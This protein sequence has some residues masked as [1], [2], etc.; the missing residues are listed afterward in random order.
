M[1]FLYRMW[2][3]ETR[4]EEQS[5]G[6]TDKYKTIKICPFIINSISGA[7]A[8]AGRRSSNATTWCCYRKKGLCF[9][10][11][12]RLWSGA[13]LTI[14]KIY[15]C[16]K[17]FSFYHKRRRMNEW[18]EMITIKTSEILSLY[19]LYSVVFLLCFECNI[20]YFYWRFENTPNHKFNCWWL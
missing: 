4:R 14:Y 7:E 11:R 18:F 8:E 15:D 13:G 16:K 6:R 10:N 2:R 9:K 12:L 5:D 3:R 1:L 20:L 17:L 19:T